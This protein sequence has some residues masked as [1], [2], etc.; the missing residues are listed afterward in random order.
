MNKII[1]NT[2]LGCSLALCLF[3]LAGCSAPVKNTYIYPYPK[4]ITS[5]EGMARL[6]HVVKGII[7]RNE[8][9]EDSPEWIEKS[10]SG[11]MIQSLASLSPDKYADY[12]QYARGGR[13]FIIV[14]PAFYTFFTRDPRISIKPS[15]NVLKQNVVERFYRHGIRIDESL[16]VMQ[17]QE[18]VQRDFVEVITTEEILT[19]MVLPRNYA[20]GLKQEMT[21]GRDEYAR[22][23]NEITNESESTLYIQSRSLDR[24]GLAR[25]DMEILIEFLKAAG[26]K[27]V[28]VGGGY[29]GRCE[30]EFYDSLNEAISEKGLN[31]SMRNYMVPEI[32]AVSP[33]DLSPSWLKGLLNNKGGI[34]FT[35]AARNLQ[36]PG[37]YD[38]LSK[39]PKLSRFYIYE[40][41]LDAKPKKKKKNK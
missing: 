15:S 40:F 35:S 5:R 14:H 31:N 26:V 18:K 20:E 22:F 13:A 27:R 11:L 33:E 36:K 23:V 39:T 1:L 28:Y 38:I 19:I 10:Y 7:E 34:N 16:V 17:E 6:K 8:T 21:G 25:G 41:D 32:S 30:S 29:I 9:V 2:S 3:L 37:A 4:E 24:G 12:A